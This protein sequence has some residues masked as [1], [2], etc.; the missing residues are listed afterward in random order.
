M[1]TAVQ[2]KNAAGSAIQPS[3]RLLSLDLIRGLTII[4][5]A[6][7][8]NPGTWDHIYAPLEHAAWNGFTPTDFVFP[9]FLFISGVAIALALSRK[10]ERREQFG[11]IM[12]SALRRCAILFFIGV[13]ITAYVIKFDFANL[14]I[15]GVLQR[16]GVVYFICSA[17]YLK[18][19]NRAMA[20]TAFS[21]L[22]AYYVLMNFVPVPGFGHPDLMNPEANIGAWLDRL[23]F[24][25]AH[26][27][28]FTKTWDPEG[29]LTTIPSVATGLFGVLTGVLLKS[30]EAPASKLKKM[31]GFGAVFIATGL[32]LNPVFAIN[33]SL[34]TS[35][36]VLF[37]AGLSMVVLGLA[38]WLIDVKGYRKWTAWPV[39]FGMNS[40]FA[41]VF[42][43][44]FPETLRKIPLPE[45]KSVYDWYYNT[46]IVPRF[47]DPRNASLLCALTLVAFMSP[48]LL[49]MRKKN[50]IVKV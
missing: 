35:S 41:Y 46:L 14:R 24:T 12:L 48:I 2:P 8:N 18:L 22:L 6:I 23:I 11:S 34:W 37:T 33:K 45:S 29:L 30:E 3:Q 27:F 15:P 50:I 7:V 40:I 47:T 20:V 16:I 13:F 25:P 32:A 38:Y 1:N 4:M 10:K 39:A 28:R 31:F 49:F 36:Y 43:E 26:L 44:L 21:C 19:G 42:S 9:N 17:L 5:M